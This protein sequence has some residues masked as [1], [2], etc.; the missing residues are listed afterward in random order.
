MVFFMKKF[1]DE[2]FF[3]WEMLGFSHLLSKLSRR[4]S[5]IVGIALRIETIESKTVYRTFS[6]AIL[7]MVCSKSSIGL[8]G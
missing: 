3:L 2:E 5:A 7:N 6:R 1:V 4:R 8:A